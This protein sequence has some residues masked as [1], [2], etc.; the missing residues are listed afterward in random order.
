MTLEGKPC[1]ER[2]RFMDGPY[3]DEYVRDILIG[4]VIDI[5]APNSRIAVNPGGLA[6]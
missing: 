4:R 2:I 5:F 6:S 3:E 1:G